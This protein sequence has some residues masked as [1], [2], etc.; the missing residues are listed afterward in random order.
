MKLIEVSH[1]T[2]PAKAADIIISKCKPFLET[3]NYNTLNETL[4]RGVHSNSRQY[5]Q[6]DKETGLRVVN[7]INPNR[8]PK[9]TDAR[10]HKCINEAFV[11]K[12]GV[13]FRNGTFTSGNLQQAHT[14]GN[15]VSVIFPIG[16]FKFLWSAE[17]DDLYIASLDVIDRFE[18]YSS[19]AKTPENIT[20]ELLDWANYQDTDLVK[21]IQSGNEIMLYCDKCILL[22]MN[23]AHDTLDVLQA[24]QQRGGL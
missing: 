5:M 13:P 7:G 14:Y 24:I 23:R 17:I 11:K 12:Y 15:M 10:I 2:N 3:I 21:G 8:Q 4:Y 18:A 9:D 19:A 1:F 22:R 20:A 6:V 16:D